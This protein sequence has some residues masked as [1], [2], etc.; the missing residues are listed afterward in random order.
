[1][2][3]GNKKN[4][5]LLIICII[6]FI[7]PVSVFAGGSMEESST[8][9]VQFE[10]SQGTISKPES[11][12]TSSIISTI[13]YNYP[14]PEEDFDIYLYSG[15]RQVP[16]NGGQQVFVLGIQGA[17]ISMDSLPPMNLCFVIDH[18]G[19]M[20]GQSKM[21]WVWESFDIFI[22]SV[23]DTDY[24]SIVK[25]DDDAE[26]VFPSSRMADKEIREQCRLAVH[27]I[28]PDGGTNLTAGIELGYQQVMTNFREEY[29][30][31][32]L[33]LTDGEGNSEGMLEMAKTFSDMGIH[34]STIGLG[35]GFN[36]E[37][38]RS[39]AK[40]GAGTSRFISDRE[41]MKEM[42]GSGLGR[43]IIPVIRNL[44]LIVKIPS[45]SNSVET[46]AYDYTIDGNSISYRY[47]ALHVGDY[48]TIVINT[49]LPEL[50]DIGK[51]TILEVGGTYTDRNGNQ[52]NIPGKTLNIQVVNTGEETDGFSNGIVLRAGTALHWAEA[53][54]EIGFLY[55]GSE[56]EPVTK[57]SP[58]WNAGIE[59]ALAIANTI[60]KELYSVQE[61]LEFEGFSDE[62][63][64]MEKYIRILGGE[65]E[66]N[67]EGINEVVTDRE[68]EIQQR[69]YPF[70]NRVETLFKELNLSMNEQ[71]KGVV[72]IT[73]FSFKNEREAPILDLLNNYAETSFINN[74]NFPVTSRQD[75]EQ[76]L[77]EQKLQLSG[78][79]E[80][81]NAITV[82]ELL[83]ARY[84]VT[85]TVIEMG[86]SVIIFTRII[87]V[88]SA[89]IIGASQI[90][91]KKDE[92]VSILLESI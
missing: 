69:E 70:P 37:L 74:V 46:W 27:S 38:L 29:T 59:K 34:V 40:A 84:M 58:D 88:E 28:N 39:L 51:N 20:G 16:I 15:N 47:P 4:I 62:I 52:K 24:V 73:G 64:V 86:S 54:K 42:F 5:I 66:F 77:N 7:T 13:D 10:A 14:E 36:G 23:R 26:I 12:I 1:M 63:S 32:V 81:K 9:S 79:F 67:E 49:E 8:G 3:N 76:V 89:E 61:R 25:F 35:S 30:N 2:R 55:Y 92:D 80:T 45:G 83:S 53:L 78:L 75:L 21:E 17:Q 85:G 56:D 44:E 82:G 90:I 11:V 22:E 31:R 41:A 87:E 50:P 72:A 60:K 65:I 6:V 48:E 43:M 19:S 18:S 33:F 71:P 57:E 91:V 68:P